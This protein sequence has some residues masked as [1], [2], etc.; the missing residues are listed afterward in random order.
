MAEEKKEWFNE[1]FSSPY[2]HILYKNRDVEEAEFFLTNLLNHLKIPAE[3]KLIDIGCGSGRHSIFLNSLGY[4]VEGIDI[5]ERNIQLAKEHENEKLHFH[6]HD[7]REDFK[8]NQYD[9]AFNLFTSFGFFDTDAEHQ[10]AISSFSNSLKAEGVLVLDFLNPYRVIHNLVADEIKTV[11]GIEFNL[12]RHFDGE[13]IIKEIK[14]EAEGKS[15]QFEERVKAI[16]R[17][18]F[19]DFFRNAHLMH[20][21]TFGDYQ[22]NEYKPE[23]SE[24]MIFV[25]KKL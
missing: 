24:R 19:L 22:L 20:L 9:Y 15:Y 16:R 3:S 6:V 10:K 17:L 23:S 7:M 2:Y 21:Q 14:F 5:S 1:W 18:S 8:T 11:E 4:E 13:C 25:A 12:R